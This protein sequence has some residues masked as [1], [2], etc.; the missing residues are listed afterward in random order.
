MNFFA[1][2][3]LAEPTAASRFGSLLADF[4]RGVELSHYP[5]TVQ[6]AVL[7][8]R[9]IDR[10]TDQ[11]EPVRA[12][13]QLFSPRY[14][15]FAPVITDLLWDHLLLIHWRQFDSRPLAPL[16][17]QFYQQLAEQLITSEPPM[18][19][20]MAHTIRLLIQQ[21]WFAHYQQLDGIAAALDSMAGRLRFA[22]QFAG[23]RQEFEPQLEQL[24]QLFCQFYPQLQHYVQDLGPELTAWQHHL[25]QQNQ[26]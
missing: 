25:A 13:R 5:A 10:F 8:H 24:Y 11:A 3:V 21:D 19:A 2:L 4:C 9:A 26:Q 1:H 14:R 22:N 6:A 20:P 12:A 17:Q 18:P 23:S 16:C 7:R 15:R